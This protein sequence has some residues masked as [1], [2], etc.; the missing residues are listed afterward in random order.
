MIPF[1]KTIKGEKSKGVNTFYRHCKCFCKR[2]SKASRNTDRENIRQH[3]QLT[4]HQY[5]AGHDVSLWFNTATTGRR[6][7]QKCCSAHAV[8]KCV[9]VN[10]SHSHCVNP[11]HCL[12]TYYLFINFIIIYSHCV[13]VCLVFISL[14]VLFVCYMRIVI[15]YCTLLYCIWHSLYPYSFITHCHFLYLLPSRYKA[16][17]KM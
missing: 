6:V 12:F 2:V 16:N 7:L 11:S 9:C 14:V 8:L 10:A 1:I 4:V 5:Q 15:M 13:W 17:Y 3:Y